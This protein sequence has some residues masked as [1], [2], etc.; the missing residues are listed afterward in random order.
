MFVLEGL[1]VG[2]LKMFSTAAKQAREE[3]RKEKAKE[4]TKLQARL[5]TELQRHEVA[6]NRLRAAT[7]H[8]ITSA[9][10]GVTGEFR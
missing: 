3:S 8:Y 1:D 2:W 10:D 5:S 6:A 7:E 9:V 4:R